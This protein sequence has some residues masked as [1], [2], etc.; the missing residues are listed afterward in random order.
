[1]NLDELIG[2][3]A[4]NNGIDK[5]TLEHGYYHIYM[6]GVEVLCSQASGVLLIEA[7]VAPL[8]KYKG[9]RG[10]DN[11][12]L[13]EKSL[14]LIRNQRCCLTL[15]E[16]SGEYWLYQRVAMDDLRVDAFQEYI[17]S[18]GGCCLYYKGLFSQG[19]SGP[20]PADGMMLP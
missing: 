16:E 20:S 19:E 2:Q 7:A 18:F 4:K 11:R 15:N 1:M 17:E 6:E 12:R 10:A 13:L 3:F 9:Q 14:G 5:P 8:A